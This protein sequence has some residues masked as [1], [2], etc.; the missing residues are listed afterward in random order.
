LQKLEHLT[1][2]LEDANDKIKK[3]EDKKDDKWR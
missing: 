3:L 1:K 2:D